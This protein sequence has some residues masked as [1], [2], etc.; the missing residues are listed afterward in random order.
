MLLL[1]LPHDALEELKA[2]YRD[3]FGETLSDDAAATLGER[4]LRTYALLARPKQ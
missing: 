3:E 2:I 1:M 4:L